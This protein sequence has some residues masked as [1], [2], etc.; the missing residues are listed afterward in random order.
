MH[1]SG[2]MPS[3]AAGKTVVAVVD[4]SGEGL[5]VGD[6]EPKQGLTTVSSA[7]D[8]RYGLPVKRILPLLEMAAGGETVSF[9]VDAANNDLFGN[10]PESGR[11]QQARLAVRH[12]ELVALG[13][14]LEV[15]IDFLGVLDA[16][17]ARAQRL[18]AKLYEATR[19]LRD[20][21][22]TEAAA[23]RAV[24]APELAKQG[25][26]PSLTLSTVGH[27]HM[28]LAWLWP[29]R[30]TKRKCARTFSTVLTLMDRYPD[31]LFGAS[32]PQQYQW[33]KD[34]YPG[35][36]ARIKDAIAA[37][38]WEAQ[39]AMWVEPDTNITG[40][41]S[42]IRQIVDG[43]QFFRDEFGVELDNL[44]E[45]DVFGYSGA[46]PQI[47]AKS[48]IK[49]FMTQ[50]LSWNEINKFPHQTFWWEG[51]DGSRVLAHMLPEE[52]YLSPVLPHSVRYA[53]YNYFDSPVA[54]EALLLFG[55]GCADRFGRAQPCAAGSPKEG[56]HAGLWPVRDP[57]PEN[58]RALKI[59]IRPM[60][61]GDA[62]AVAGL[63]AQLGYPVSAGTVTVRLELISR[64]P[65]HGFF[66]AEAGGEVVGWV[67]VYGVRLLESPSFFAEI[68][69]LV[70]DSK[71]RRLGV[72]RSLMAAA[73]KWAS[74]HGFPEVRL[75]SGLHRTDA[76][77]FY[78]SIGYALTKTS[79]LFRKAVGP[80]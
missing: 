26:D 63:S 45:L 9:W 34:E 58:H 27:A 68:G 71:A 64:S 40:G 60:T 22:D 15:L 37:G 48:G 30:E 20:F 1:F 54:E 29:I 52:S 24:L 74:E 73:E 76:H 4:F 39:G 69:G 18:K 3:E 28:D 12:P 10:V 5:V 23:A 38:R 66:V 14:D 59:T 36:Y 6:D 44:W 75:R 43:K 2:T 72:G 70:V 79:Y 16:K 32:Q 25:G 46:L 56:G 77:Q 51:I 33:M 67:H 8:N 21:T 62:L 31:Y 35:L 13:Y 55:I 49:Y 53:E 65:D 7:F 80:P 78:Q 57:H 50:K 19:L 47:L 61:A 41:E 42:L 11:L 17:S